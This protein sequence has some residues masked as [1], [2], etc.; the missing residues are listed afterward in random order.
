MVASNGG[1]F[2]QRVEAAFP[3]QREAWLLETEDGRRYRYQ[4]AVGASARY[5]NLLRAAGLHKGD[6]L[7]VQVEKSPEALFVYLGCLR[8]GVIF[9]PLNPA[10][11]SEEVGFFLEDAEPAAVVCDPTAAAAAHGRRRSGGRRVLYTLDAQGGGSLAEAARE[12][13]TRFHDE[14]SAEEEVAAILYTSG[15][16]G[17]PKGAMITHRN[18]ASNGE[19]LCAIWGF[20]ADDVLLHALPV[21]HAHGLFTALHCV[22]L[23]GSR[24]LL[25]RRF[26]AATACRLLPRATVF[27]GVPTFYTRLLSERAFGAPVC[28]DVRL[29]TSGSAPLLPETFERFERRVGR[30]IVERYGT[31]EAMIITSNPLQGERRAGSVGRALPGIEVRIADDQGRA[32]EAGAPGS[33]Q[34]RGPNVFK[35]Y[36]RRPQAS[37]K[38]F[39][40]DGFFVT[41]DLG[42]VDAE[43]YVTLVGRTSDLI[44]SGGYNV[45]PRE[46]ENVLD[47]MRGVEESSVFGVPHPDFGEGVVAAVRVSAGARDLR[48]PD[49]IEYANARLANY[50]VPKRVVFLEQLPTNPMGK[51]QK[52]VLRERY[53]TLFEGGA[54]AEHT[55][56]S[57]QEGRGEVV[58]RSDNGV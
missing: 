33:V 8:A 23:S 12:H 26:E 34:C 15:T 4:D 35:G 49:V 22:L 54:G 21:F 50:K 58:D 9:V 17:R 31:T 5:A 37:A 45:Y 57:S 10:Y 3:A 30:R 20:Q 46:V 11:R 42:R 16:T 38:A 18:L 55:S 13:A 1:G 25:M 53:G 6:R 43:G 39:T 24:M 27:M 48:E 41:G 47:G 56:S 14:A 52:T 40:P 29:F 7:L 28:A 36:W 2:Y 32:L 44:I 19:A 51:V